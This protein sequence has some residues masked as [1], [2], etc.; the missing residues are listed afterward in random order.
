MTRLV[1]P[2]PNKPGSPRLYNLRED[3]AE[4]KD[5]AGDRPAVVR[6]LTA[7]L[8]THIRNGRSTPGEPRKNDAE[9]PLPA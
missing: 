4:T 2:P 6:E 1:F 9:V 5:V 8:H 7:L 3:L